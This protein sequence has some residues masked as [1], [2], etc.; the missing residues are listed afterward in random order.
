MVTIGSLWLAIV[1]SAI[2][3]WIASALVW[4]V[5]PHHKSEFKGLPDEDSARKVLGPQNLTPGQYNIP[6][7][8]SWDDM[9]QPEARQRFEEGPVAFLTVVPN[10]TPAMARNMVL[11]FIF[12]LLVGTAVAYVASRSLASS[13]DYLSVFRLTGTVAWL[14]YGAALI[15]DAIWFGRP[16]NTVAKHV[17]DAFVYGLLTAGVFAWLWVS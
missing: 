17:I 5:R 4:M 16:W 11:S 14:A 3:V 10:G 1:L 8:K 2:L 9:K 13:D 7:C 12:Y 15:P 6:H